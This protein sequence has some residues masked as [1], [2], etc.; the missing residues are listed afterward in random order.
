MAGP[1]LWGAPLAIA[2]R[3]ASLGSL[4]GS[5]ASLCRAACLARWPHYLS[6]IGRPIKVRLAACVPCTRLGRSASSACGIGVA[7]GFGRGVGVG[8]GRRVAA[9]RL[10]VGRTLVCGS[11]ARSPRRMLTAMVGL[12][13]GSIVLSSVSSWATSEQSR[14]ARVPRGARACAPRARP[15]PA[16]AS[17]RS[18]APEWRGRAGVSARAR[19][20]VSTPTG[21]PWP[22]S[23][24][25]RMRV[26]VR[27]STCLLARHGLMC[28]MHRPGRRRRRAQRL[29]RRVLR[30]N[31]ARAAPSGGCCAPAPAEEAEVVTDVRP[32]PRSD[33]GSGVAS[34]AQS[35]RR[36]RLLAGGRGRIG[37]MLWSTVWLSWGLD[38]VVVGAGLDGVV[39]HGAVRTKRVASPSREAVSG[40]VGRSA[41]RAVRPR[42][43]RA[44]CRARKRRSVRGGSCWPFAAGAFTQGPASPRLCGRRSVS[45]ALTSRSSSGER[46]S[47]TR[48]GPGGAPGCPVRWRNRWWARVR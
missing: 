40:S 41:S 3:L 16:Y 19:V 28:R 34:H 35:R 23:G 20:R 8:G 17:P 21:S 39:M 33:L 29:V 4:D 6:A 2:G 10:L 12:G 11:A 1:R 5:L 25:L 24:G 9:L 15:T 32:G 38:G 46:S 14:A 42:R 45:G 26:R 27:V 31:A 43:A 7:V 47:I 18:C 13:L 22:R 44:A 36:D 48:S 30:L 37:R